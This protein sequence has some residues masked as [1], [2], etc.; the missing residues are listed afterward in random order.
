MCYDYSHTELGLPMGISSLYQIA[1]TSDRGSVTTHENG[2]FGAVSRGES[3]LT[4][5]F[6]FFLISIRLHSKKPWPYTRTK[7]KC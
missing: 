4:S 1:L 2:D 5:L 6:T 7:F 3:L